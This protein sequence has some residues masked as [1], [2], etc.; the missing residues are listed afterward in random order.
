[1]PKL[2]G[3]RAYPHTRCDII[4]G[5]PAPECKEIWCEVGKW[6]HICAKAPWKVSAFDGEPR[7][8]PAFLASLIEAAAARK[9]VNGCNEKV[10]G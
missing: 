9:F 8:P 6:C 2:V 5:K 3:K 4:H 7:L 10:K 1:M